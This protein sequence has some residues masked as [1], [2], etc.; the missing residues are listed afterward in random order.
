MAHSVTYLVVQFLRCLELRALLQSGQL[1]QSAD[2][3]GNIRFIRLC[4]NTGF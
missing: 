4:R 2:A 1:V 3:L